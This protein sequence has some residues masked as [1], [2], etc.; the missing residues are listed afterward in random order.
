MGGWI[1]IVKENKHLNVQQRGM[2]ELIMI[3]G[4]KEYK[5]KYYAAILND[6]IKYIYRQWKVL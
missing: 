6:A 1:L 3:Y 2:V 5:V 4:H